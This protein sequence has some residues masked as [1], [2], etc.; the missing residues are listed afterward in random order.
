MKNPGE[1]KCEVFGDGHYYIFT[2]GRDHIPNWD[3]ADIILLY[4]NNF[5]EI[6]V[7]YMMFETCVS[8]RL[9]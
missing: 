4:Y 1:F 9:L 7:Q 3:L 8:V 6:I 2:I 5:D